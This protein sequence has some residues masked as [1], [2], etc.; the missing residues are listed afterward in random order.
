M[1]VE[2]KS[3]FSIRQLLPVFALVLIQNSQALADS[4][5]ISEV[6][7]LFDRSPSVSTRIPRH[8]TPDDLNGTHAGYSPSD[9]RAAY[10]LDPVNK[11]SDG[12]SGQVIAIID[13]YGSSTLLDD[14]NAFSDAYGLPEMDSDSLTIA[15]VVIK[16]GK[17]S[18]DPSLCKSKPPKGVTTAVLQDSASETT[19]DVE[20]AHAI[21]PGAKILVL[22]APDMAI[23]SAAETIAI[24]TQY[25]LPTG[26]KA[27]QVSMSFGAPES[28]LGADFEKQATSIF[29]GATFIAAAGDAGAQVNWPSVDP[30]VLAVGGT[31][32]HYS[33]SG[34]TETAWSGSGG[35]VSTVFDISSASYQSPWQT[36]GFRTVPDVAANADFKNTPYSF[37]CSVSSCGKS[38]SFRSVE[39]RRGDELRLPGLGGAGRSSQCCQVVEQ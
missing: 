35:G 8:A 16:S 3:S 37:Y 28:D 39:H 19:V 38:F 29:K 20:W 14:V 27:G 23:A 12:G 6:P 34:T 18:A 30:N 10:G 9:I 5:A 36:T 22:L 15:C 4:L 1:F 21:A 13:A 17:V 7:A 11:S 26:E 24:A 33:N 31:T 32:L 2:K 25:S